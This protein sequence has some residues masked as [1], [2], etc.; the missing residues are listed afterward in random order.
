MLPSVV[1]WGA[2]SSFVGLVGLVGLAGL[3]ACSSFGAEDGASESSDASGSDVSSGETSL[4]DGASTDAEA[5][6]CDT[7]KLA[8][9]T[10][11]CGACGRRCETSCESGMCKP[12]PLGGPK[13]SLPTGAH[14]VV[15]ETSIFVSDLSNIYECATPGF[16]L[17]CSWT[18]KLA[19]GRDTFLTPSPLALSPKRLFWGT[20]S[21]AMGT[22]S[23]LWSSARGPGAASTQ[24]AAPDAFALAANAAATSV[25]LIDS[26]NAR[27]VH[28]FQCTDSTCKE[29]TTVG[30]NARAITTNGS[31]IC[32]LG[33]ASQASFGLVCDANGSGTVNLPID[34]DSVGVAMAGDSAFVVSPQGVYAAKLGA[35][36]GLQEI[37][38]VGGTGPIVADQK[39]VY[40]ASNSTIYRCSHTDCS[41][42]SKVSDRPGKVVTELGIA[43]D[44]LYFLEADPTVSLLRIP[45]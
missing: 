28:E 4:P 30:T 32:F 25:L 13:L 44:Y 18:P 7:T 34:P 45:K 11:N 3:G 36:P 31:R 14:F 22:T 29:L 21:S 23:S 41:S 38:K 12:L 19:N 43:G 10:L 5:G 16:G 37:G 24:S 17:A 9:D 40:F 42:P 15:D 35:M 1:R 2:A 20:S 26:T 6:P 27:T 39:S 8:T 33:S